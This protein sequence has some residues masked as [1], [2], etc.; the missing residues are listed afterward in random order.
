MAV[1]TV[2]LTDLDVVARAVMFGPRKLR[3]DVVNMFRVANSKAEVPYL[4]NHQNP[5]QETLDTAN[6]DLATGVSGSNIEAD[7]VDLETVFTAALFGPRENRISIV[8]LARAE[9]DEIEYLVNAAQPH[10]S[11][12][13]TALGNIEALL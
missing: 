3:L 13:D 7:T 6:N 12:V 4:V 10:Q 8:N 9:E 1:I 11:A 5:S 2:P